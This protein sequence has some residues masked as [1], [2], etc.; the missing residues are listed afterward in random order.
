[1][2]HLAARLPPLEAQVLERLLLLAPSDDTN[3]DTPVNELATAAAEGDAASRAQLARVV[4]AAA[5]KECQHVFSSVFQAYTSDK[6]KQIAR[7]NVLRHGDAAAADA[8]SSKVYG[9][10]EFGA[11]ANL[12]ERADIQTGETLFDLG[13]GTGKALVAASLLF[14]DRLAAAEGVELLEDLQALADTALA[15][16]RAAL[17]GTPATRDLFAS[18]AGCELR[19]AQ[20]DFLTEPW[21]AQ[22]TKADIVFANSTCFDH[23]LMQRIAAIAERMRPGARLITFTRNLPSAAFEVTEKVNLGMSWGVAT[24]YIHRRI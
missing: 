7:Q 17:V 9:E 3:D 1:M 24:C 10:V 12:L 21:A 14:G 8:L 5:Y 4:S 13:S 19:A 11:F 20:G 6:S 22:W 23:D 2:A 16:Y 15:S 18:R